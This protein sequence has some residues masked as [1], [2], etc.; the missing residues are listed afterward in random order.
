MGLQRVRYDWATELNWILYQ[1]SWDIW[2][3]FLGGSDS[4]ESV[5]NAGDLG[6]IPVLG[7]S[8]G[9]GNPLLLP[10]ESHGQRSLA[11]YRLWSPRVRHERVTSTFTFFH[12][13]AVTLFK[14]VSSWNLFNILV[15]IRAMP[16]YSIGWLMYSLMSTV[17]WVFDL[18][19]GSNIK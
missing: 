9:E 14:L 11:G 18:E 15:M 7:R 13:Y 4:K 1:I 12:K 17:F 8:P 2:I 16:F 10:G 6:L 5:C 3:Y 19:C